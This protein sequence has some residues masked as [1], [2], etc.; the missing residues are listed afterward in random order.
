MLPLITLCY[1]VALVMSHVPHPPV[2][3]WS[4]HK[5]ADYTEVGGQKGLRDSY[6]MA[7]VPKVY[8]DRRDSQHGTSFEDR[9][10]GYM[11]T[12]IDLGETPDTPGQ[13]RGHRHTDSYLSA[14]SRDEFDDV[15]D[16]EQAHNIHRHS[17]T[18]GTLSTVEWDATQ[19]QQHQQQ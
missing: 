4:K 9:R 7:S 16:Y 12:E 2:L 1:F 15:V 18:L 5:G 8:E 17:G 10:T 3:G 14:T 19:H 6:Q 13:G 11:E